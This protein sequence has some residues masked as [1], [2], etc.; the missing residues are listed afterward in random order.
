ME[1]EEAFFDVVYDDVHWQRRNEV[2][3]SHWDQFED[4]QG[5][6]QFS[7]PDTEPAA[8]GPVILQS[9]EEIRPS[10]LEIVDLP[11]LVRDVNTPQLQIE[12][13]RRYSPFKVWQV[14]EL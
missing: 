14:A 6:S 8:G 13:R 12:P 1:F 10:Q 9:D 5:L 2:S 7:L 11:E 4:V 3:S